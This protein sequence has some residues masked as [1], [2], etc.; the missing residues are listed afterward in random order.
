MTKSELITAVAKDH[1]YLSR[2]D[3]ERAVDAIFDEIVA[4]LSRGERVEI[5]GLA[6]F[7]IRQKRARL[8]RNPKTGD[9]VDI[10]AK[11]TVKLRAGRD[12]LNVI[13][14]NQTI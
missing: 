8:G 2:G 1:S 14:A 6:S 3:V 7:F 11:S 12:L 4:S 5:R 13:N 9:T 10:Q